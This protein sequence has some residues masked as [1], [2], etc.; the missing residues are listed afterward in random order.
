[1]RK[2]H[3]YTLDNWPRRENGELIFDSTNE[4]IYYAH[5]PIDRL[6][7]YDLLKKWRKN[8]YQNLKREKT[9]KP[10]NFNRIFDLAV[11]AQLYRECMEEIER[12][13]TEEP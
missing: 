9:L 8:A 10:V 1:M 13:N 11:R 7:A 2:Y 6:S 5:L 12:L 3:A 4:A